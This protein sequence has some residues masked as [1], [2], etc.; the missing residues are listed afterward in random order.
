MTLIAFVA[1]P[2]LGIKIQLDYFS[3]PI[4]LRFVS[5]VKSYYP[6]KYLLCAKTLHPV[7]HHHHFLF[8]RANRAVCCD[9]KNSLNE[10]LTNELMCFRMDN[11]SWPRR[12]SCEKKRI[13][14]SLLDQDR[15]RPFKLKI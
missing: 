3:S 5:L 6:I 10:H 14:K 4:P 15:V 9:P 11:L 13:F 7:D 8:R 1:V 12:G 2:K